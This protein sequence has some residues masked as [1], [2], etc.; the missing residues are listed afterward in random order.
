MRGSPCDLSDEHPML[1]RDCLA[2][3]TARDT[4]SEC[5]P[6]PGQSGEARIFLI[7]DDNLTA[8]VPLRRSILQSTLR[9]K[10]RS[11]GRH[12]PQ[13]DG[14]P[15]KG[16]YRLHPIALRLAVD[17]D[18][19]GRSAGQRRHP[20]D[21]ALLELLRIERGEDV[22]KMIMRWCS[23]GE[24][25][26][27]AQKLALLGPEAGDLDEAVGSRQNRQQ[28]QQ[29]HLVERVDHL[30]ALP[31]VRQRSKMIQKNNRLA[32]SPCRVHR[33][34]PS[35]NQRRSMDSELYPVVTHSFTRLPWLAG[36]TA[37]RASNVRV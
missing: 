1:P 27:P 22:A 15:E 11:T 14:G 20:G 5:A 35:P 21:E 16:L 32:Q 13:R 30:A 17:R 6:M 19:P 23:L 34:A 26:E 12:N 4:V 33:A 9:Q 25:P 2:V 24:R 36:W 10:Y 37:L 7:Q 29:Q 28:A 18:H 3:H 31:R 8:E